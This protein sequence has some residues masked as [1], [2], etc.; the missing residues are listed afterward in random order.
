MLQW[1][2]TL[3]ILLFTTPAVFGGQFQN[4]INFDYGNSFRSD[5]VE[6]HLHLVMGTYSQPNTFFRQL[7]KRNIHVGRYA[8]RPGKR[9]TEPKRGVSVFGLSQ[10][11]IFGPEKL[12]FTVGLG[13]FICSQGTD[14]IGSKFVFREKLGL[15]AYFGAYNLEVSAIHISNGTLQNPN[16]GEN[17]AVVSFGYRY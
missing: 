1:F 17:F 8:G 12:Y 10:D 2:I 11:V 5:G 4:Q 9:G 14:R 6:E 16:A 7:G 15:G 3:T 13:A